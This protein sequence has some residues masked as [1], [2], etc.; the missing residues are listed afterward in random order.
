ML[1]ILKSPAVV[2]VAVVMLLGACG[3]FLKLHYFGLT[4]S[5]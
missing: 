2:A 5:M 1:S 3:A 4:Y